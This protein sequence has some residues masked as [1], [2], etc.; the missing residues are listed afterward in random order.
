MSTAPSESWRIRTLLTSGKPF[1]RPI[2]QERLPRHLAEGQ[3]DRVRLL[4]ERAPPYYPIPQHCEM[5][6]TRAPPSRIFFCCLVAPRGAGGETP[7]ADFRKVYQD[8]DPEV[9][10]RRCISRR[11]SGTRGRRDRL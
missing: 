9:R 5:S 11:S 2:P 8:L 7:I 10:R 6:F 3:P 1:A 4:G